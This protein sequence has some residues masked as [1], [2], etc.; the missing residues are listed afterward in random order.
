[1]AAVFLSL[2]VVLLY[3]CTNI[4]K[5]NALLG[6]L[7]GFYFIVLVGAVLCVKF[8]VYTWYVNPFNLLLF[9]FVYL[10]SANQFKYIKINPEKLIHRNAKNL[11]IFF[12]IYILAASAYIYFALPECIDNI[13]SGDYLILYEDIRSGTIDKFSGTI[14]KYLY[15]IV[16]A[17]NYPALIIGFIYLCKGETKKGICLL[18]IGVMVI[19][20]HSARIIS[21]TDLFQ[22]AVVTSLL[23]FIWC[24]SLPVKIKRTLKAIILPIAIILLFLFFAISISRSAYKADYSWVLNYLGRSPLT[25]NSILEYPIAKHQGVYFLGT[26]DSFSLNH[27]SYTGKEF[28]PLLGRMYIDFGFIGL[29][30]FLLIP[31]FLPKHPVGVSELYVIIYIFNTVLMGILYSNFVLIPLLLAIIVYIILKYILA[32]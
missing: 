13:R 1:M 10:F 4:R 21:R 22:I 23:Y 26:L 27:P 32:L 24:K 17:F 11:D 9:T 12:Y 19:V 6:Y 25:F 29:F 7:I 15:Y 16:S 3:T 20:L 31:L 5:F 2:F 30:V 8:D 18:C 28:V 14:E